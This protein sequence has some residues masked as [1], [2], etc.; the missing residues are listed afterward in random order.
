MGRLSYEGMA[1][2]W[3]ARSGD[4]YSDRINSMTK[5][6]VSSTLTDPKWANTT[7]LRDDPLDE[8]RRLKQEP[9]QDVVQYR[10]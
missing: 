9:G 4:P 8:I 7:V 5:Y 6:V 10:A 1:E 3:M 2:A